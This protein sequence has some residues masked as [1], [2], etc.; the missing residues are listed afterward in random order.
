MTPSTHDRD[1]LYTLLPALYRIADQ[2]G[3]GPLRALLALINDEADALRDDTRQLWDNS[4]IETC[5]RWAIPYIGDLVGNNLL[6]DLDQSDAATT[7]AELFHDLTGPDLKA[8]VAIHTRADV[9]KTIYYRRRKGVTAMLE[10]LAR[11]VTDWDA[12]V[13]EFF[14]LLDWNQHLEHLRLDNHGCPDLR[15]AA[16]G[17]SV[18][19]PWQSAAHTVDVRAI[20]QYDGWHNIHNVGFF[21]WRLGAWR[22]TQAKPR[23]LA[24]YDGC[25]SFNPLGQDTKLFC[26]GG[27]SGDPG[28]QAIEAEVEA[29]I[30]GSQLFAD[31]QGRTAL[32]VPATQRYYGDGDHASVGVWVNGVLLPPDRVAC[33]NLA[34]WGPRPAGSV[35]LID[36]RLGRLLIPA[37]LT[38]EDIRS[39]EVSYC[40][41]FS[42]AMGGGEYDRARWLLRADADIVRME[43]GTPTYPTLDAAID[44]WALARARNTVITLHGSGSHLLTRNLELH[45][46]AWLAIEAADKSR[47]HV[48]VPSGALTIDGALTGSSLTLSGLLIEGGIELKQDLRKLRL[49]HSTLV[50]GRS[51]AQDAPAMGG[52]SLSVAESRNGN[53]I[54]TRLEVEIA[55]CICGALRVPAHALRFTLLDSIVKGILKSGDADGLAVCDAAGS[56]GPSAHIERSTIFGTSRFRQ[57]PMAS[58]SI[59]TGNVQV[60]QLQQG[61]VRFCFVPTG[62][63]TPQKYRCQPALQIALEKEETKS[64]A[65]KAGAL[66]PFGWEA[67]VEERVNAWLVPSFESDIYGR[68]DFAQLH[69]TCPVQIR[70]GAADGAEMGAFCALQ[71]PQRESNLRIRLDEY[72]PVGLEA[73]IIYVT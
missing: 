51:V 59:F 56:S 42:A 66:L 31:L 46:S 34:Q 69:L 1:R 37:G 24:G 58:E 33:A 36:A 64:R 16:A 10:E 50:P 25:L 52:T 61:C 18:D 4:F 35:V 68:S 55:F 13:V 12:R 11:D 7:A 3:N 5:Q 6:H 32:N 22:V 72:L 38:P 43:V 23:A 30:R 54:N 49:L 40:Y 28:Q 44:A 41:G 53:T 48:R 17:E 14:S 9:A 29:P 65:S 45:T 70:T 19:S 27:E 8:P 63:S 71:Q 57:L 67:L 20:N 2:E 47:P 62:S 60:D 39:I 21:I 73:A 26:V 15:R